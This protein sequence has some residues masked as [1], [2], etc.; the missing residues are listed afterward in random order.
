M[1]TKRIKST[2]LN[3]VA[4]HEKYVKQAVKE[5]TPLCLVYDNKSMI[6]PFEEIEKRGKLGK[7]TF[8]DKFSNEFYRLVYFKFKPDETQQSLL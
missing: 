3:Q 1:I 6:I 5:Q 8:L 7:E 4:I 2:F